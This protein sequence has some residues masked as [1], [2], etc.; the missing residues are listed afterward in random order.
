MAS[1]PVPIGSPLSWPCSSDLPPPGAP[2]THLELPCSQWT[3]VFLPPG[4]RHRSG[5]GFPGRQHLPPRA[6]VPNGLMVFPGSWLLA[7]PSCISPCLS[8]PPRRLE[9]FLRKLQWQEPRASRA[10]G[11][12]TTPVP[13]ILRLV[14]CHWRAGS[15]HLHV[16]AAVFLWLNGHFV[17]FP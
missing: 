5:R 4:G 2:V 8:G 17:D 7:L 10:G 3:A 12:R 15:R 6:W 9:R 16:C 13:C 14:S 1:V 11:P